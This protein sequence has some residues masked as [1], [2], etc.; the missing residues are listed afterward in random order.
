MFT[1]LPGSGETGLCSQEAEA[2]VSLRNQGQPVLQ[3]FREKP[4]LEKTNNKK[5]V[6]F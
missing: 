4:C 5:G 6:L 3:S 2:G 1:I